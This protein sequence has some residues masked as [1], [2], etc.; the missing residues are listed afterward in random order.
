MEGTNK[1][2]SYRDYEIVEDNLANFQKHV[3]NYFENIDSCLTTFNQH[4]I[5]QSFYESGNFGKEME[6]EISKLKAALQKYYEAI[7]GA[8]GLIN[9]TKSI[10]EYQKELLNSDYKG[11][12]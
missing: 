4:E 6:K 7:S 8:N 12:Y 5:V 10:T 9:T 3:E 1:I 2:L 11:G